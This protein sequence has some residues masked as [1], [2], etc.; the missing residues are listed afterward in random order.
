MG[1]PAPTKDVMAAL[2]S[3]TLLRRLGGAFWEAFSGGAGSGAKM[4]VWDAE[5]VLRGRAVVR[6][7]DV[8]ADARRQVQRA[9]A[10]GEGKKEMCLLAD[11]LVE[12]MNGLDLKKW[13]AVSPFF[14][15]DG[16]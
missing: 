9:T 10:Q 14:S 12:S 7:V 6:V 1:T 13:A 2:A 11:M 3:Q 4:G 5:E 8:D 15:Y 16:C